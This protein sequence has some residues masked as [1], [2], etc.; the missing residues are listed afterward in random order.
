MKKKGKK[1]LIKL[2][3]IVCSA[4]LLF[5]S[6]CVRYIDTSSIQTVYASDWA[7]A[8]GGVAVDVILKALIGALGGYAAKEAYEAYED[9][10]NQSFYDY[11]SAPGRFADLIGEKAKDTCVKIYDK[12][13]NTIH[14]ISW[15]EM[16]ES[17][18]S[19]HDAVVD[20]L[21]NLYAQYC[22]ALLR[23]FEDFITDILDG[24][25]YVD[26]LSSEFV[27]YE[28]ITDADIAEQLSGLPYTYNFTVTFASDRCDYYTK[29]YFDTNVYTYSNSISH[30]VAGYYSPDNVTQVTTDDGVTTNRHSVSF[31]PYYI[32]SSG[33]I[34]SVPGSVIMT[35]I[36]NGKSSSG[37]NIA[38]YAISAYW[39]EQKSSYSIYNGKFNVGANFPVFSNR[40]DYLNY[41]YTG[42]GYESAINYGSSI[43]DDIESNVDIPPFHRG[44][45]QEFWERIANA[46]DVIGIGSYGNGVYDD[47]WGDDIPWIGLESLQEYSRSLLD[48]YNQIINDILNGTYDS[49]EDIPGTYSEAWEQA[50]SEAWDNVEQSTDAVPGEKDKPTDGDEDEKD[51]PEGGGGGNGNSN[52]DQEEP[53]EGGDDEIIDPNKLEH[54][55]GNEQHNLG[56]FLNSFNGDRTAAYIALLNATQEYIQTNDITGTFMNIVVEVNGFFITVRGTVVDGIVKIGTAFIP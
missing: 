43:Y 35:S 32:S 16:M 17:F 1:I 28:N 21:T 34:D 14:E 30:R 45:Q 12:A 37:I 20:D 46:P 13:S 3:A 4:M 36:R 6:P 5:L 25:V 42:E 54:I 50:I 49:S 52:N 40:E 55:F 39:Y 53:P 31:T 22:P 48:I 18:S 15:E 26:G 29:T 9:E 44:W 2:L 38:P 27:E 11:I 56:D 51:G 47:D 7:I 24:D 33:Y 10:I 41:L 8:G 19:G 23:S